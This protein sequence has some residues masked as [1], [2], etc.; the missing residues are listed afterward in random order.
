LSVELVLREPIGE[1][2]LEG[3]AFP[4]SLGG[5]GTAVTL[6]AASGTLAWIGLHDGQLFVQPEGDA[7]GVLH[8]GTPIAGSTWLRS[9]DVLDAGGGRLKL[10]LEEGRR[11]LELVQRLARCS[12][13]HF[14][15]RCALRV[16]PQA[17]NPQ[18][19][20]ASS[21]RDLLAASRS[22]RLGT[23]PFDRNRELN[24]VHCITDPEESTARRLPFSAIATVTHAR[25]S[26]GR[27]R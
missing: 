22:M 6:P 2:L 23:S 15:H 24:P 8:N 7:A 10:R 20:R 25:F 17:C 11:V 9:G 26:S 4:L 27:V 16:L 12:R 21:P 13:I 18:A 14:E 3:G 5:P 19:L 1:R